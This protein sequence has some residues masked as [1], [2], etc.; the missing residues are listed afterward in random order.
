MSSNTS[1]SGAVASGSGSGSDKK[2]PKSRGAR[3]LD[4]VGGKAGEIM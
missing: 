1:P 4:A 3:T 2:Q